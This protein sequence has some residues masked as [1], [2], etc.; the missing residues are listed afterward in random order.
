MFYVLFT[1]YFVCI[2]PLTENAAIH[3]FMLDIIVLAAT[4]LRGSNIGAAVCHF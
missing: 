4:F 1:H 2:V 3:V